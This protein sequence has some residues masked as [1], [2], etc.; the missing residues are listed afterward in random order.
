MACTPPVTGQ[1]LLMSYVLHNIGMHVF[2]T[3]WMMRLEL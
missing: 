2:S 1:R 3:C